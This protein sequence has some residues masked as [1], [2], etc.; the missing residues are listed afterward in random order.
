[1]KMRGVGGRALVGGAQKVGRDLGGV[2]GEGA[3]PRPKSLTATSGSDSP[4]HARQGPT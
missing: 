3:G 4:L 1:M 2:V